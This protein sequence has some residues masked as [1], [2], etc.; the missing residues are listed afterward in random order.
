[1]TQTVRVTIGT[2]R[3]KLTVEQEAPLIETLVGRGYRLRD[4]ASAE[5]A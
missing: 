5:S 3:R 4:A 1:M 2:L